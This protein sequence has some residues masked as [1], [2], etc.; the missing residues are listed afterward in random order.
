MP[1]TSS[2]SYDQYRVGSAGSV[3]LFVLSHG[4][5]L[6]LFVFTPPS[7]VSTGRFFAAVSFASFSL[8]YLCEKRDA[9]QQRPQP[10]AAAAPS[11]E[12]ASSRPRP[13]KGTSE[14]RSLGWARP[15]WAALRAHG[16]PAEAGLVPKGVLEGRHP[17]TIGVIRRRHAG[18][19]AACRQ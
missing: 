6:V 13:P 15:R 14:Q 12:G 1:V 4:V 18:V 9:P 19:G 10:N 3:L 5:L 7:R 16:R 8:L 17:A 2:A 11:S